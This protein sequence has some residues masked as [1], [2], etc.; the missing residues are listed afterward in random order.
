MKKEFAERVEKCLP[1][2]QVKAKHQR[3]VGLLQLPP[4]LEWKWE[5]IYMDFVTS[6]QNCEEL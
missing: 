5:K 1:R 4:I 2:Q 6:L 3:V